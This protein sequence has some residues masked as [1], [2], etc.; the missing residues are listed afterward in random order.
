MDDMIPNQDPSASEHQGGAISDKS[1]SLSKTKK[2]GALIHQIG[3]N[4]VVVGV[5]ALL[6]VIA[7]QRFF[8]QPGSAA[9]A[10]EVASS[11]AG[12]NA[13]DPVAVE[14]VQ[15][16]ALAPIDTPAS[17]M[18][19]GI[20]RKINVN[21]IIPSRPRDT[22]IT[23]TVNTGDT[24]FSI[25]YDY[26]LKPETLLWG[27]SDSLD[28]N[29]HLLKPNQVLRVLPVDGIYYKWEEGNRISAIAA[30]FKVEPD[31]IINYP[32]NNFDLTQVDSDGANIQPGTWL[33]VPGGWRPIKDW[34]PPAITRD[35]P[36]TARY[37]GEGACGAIYSGAIGTGTFI[38]PTT[39]RG[40]SG[41][42]FD[43]SV[44]PAIDI[45]GT[46]GNPVYATDSGVIVYAGW[47]AYGYGQLIVIDHG[48]GWQSAYAH[49]SVVG[50][51]C[52]QSVY[53]GGYIGALGNTGNSTGAHLHFEL[54]YNGVKVNPLGYVS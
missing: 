34:G 48:N 12:E 27:N 45:A 20:S 7:W 21:T 37:Y 3:L 10:P 49:L 30:Q 40:V 9:P 52:G 2:T 43:P 1:D 18:S 42:G 33:I 36:A 51:S 41:Y 17:L 26:G 25:A 24:L 11:S 28:D 47:S 13:G 6:A 31:A 35:N 54:S 16:V 46:E 22:V 53:Q 8:I 50:V 15:D 4:M 19:E 32:G 14:P 5:I 29:P 23:Y 39:D 44:H 38:W